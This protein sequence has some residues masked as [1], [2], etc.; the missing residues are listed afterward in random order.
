MRSERAGLRPDPPIVSTEEEWD[1][2]EG[3]RWESLEA[4]L[5]END[6]PEVRGKHLELKERYLRWGRACM[7]WAI[8][9]GRR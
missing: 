7:G 8:F 4:W 3:L 9:V 6:D 1:A 2:Y 5:G